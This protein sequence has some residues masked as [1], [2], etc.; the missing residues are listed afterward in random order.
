M[1]YFLCNK[2]MFQTKKFYSSH[3]A[4]VSPIIPIMSYHNA[5]LEKTTIIKQNKSKSG[6]YR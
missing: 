3:S 4:N 1:L 5:D 6:I 2:M